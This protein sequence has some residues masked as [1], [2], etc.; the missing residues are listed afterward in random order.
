MDQLVD[1]AGGD[2]A[3]FCQIEAEVA[4]VVAQ[5][6]IRLSEFSQYMISMAGEGESHD[7]ACANIPS[8]Y[9]AVQSACK[10]TI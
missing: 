2:V 9:I 4:L 5:V 1:L 10:L 3:L 7:V 8:I 6:E